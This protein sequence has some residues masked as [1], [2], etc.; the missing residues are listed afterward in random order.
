MIMEDVPE[1]DGPE[2]D[3]YLDKES[4]IDLTVAEESPTT[5]LA[6]RLGCVECT[7]VSMPAGLYPK[8]CRRKHDPDTVVRCGDCGKKHSKASLVTIP[9]AADD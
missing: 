1:D 5:T 7:D 6:I 9:E 4:I 3:E 8:P 2:R